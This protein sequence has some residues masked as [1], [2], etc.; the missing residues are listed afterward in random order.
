MLRNLLFIAIFVPGLFAA[1]RSRYAALLLYFWYAF[2]RPEDY[3]WLDVSALRLSLMLG[4]ILLVPALLSGEFPD[5]RHPLSVGAIVFFIAALVAQL[6]ALDPDTGWRW[7][8]FMTK[9]LLVSLLSTTLVRDRPKFLLAVAVIALSFGFHAS[10]AGLYSLLRGGAR[11]ADGFGGAYSDNNGYATAMAM[12]GPLLFCV[13]QN[14]TV[15]WLRWGCLMALPLVAL[16]VVATYSRSGFLALIGATL[17]MIV[18]QP[19]RRFSLLMLVACLSLPIAVF[20]SNQEGY[21]ERMQTIRTYREVNE[22]SAVSRTHFWRVAL[23]MVEANPLGVGLFNYEAAYDHYDFLHGQYG[24]KRSVHSSHFQVLAETGVLGALA[25][26]FN[27]SYAMLVLRRVRRRAATI[28]D[29]DNRRALTTGAN[30]LFASMV[31][32]LI[33]GAFIALALNDLTWITFGLVAALDRL[34]IKLQ[35]V[36]ALDDSPSRWRPNGRY[37]LDVRAPRVAGA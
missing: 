23:D 5:V 35:P 33:G 2:F 14:T 13:A 7:I 16:G 26:I 18:M 25:W 12:I 8:D 31:A 9:L 34:S 6:N 22:T 37:G 28:V 32:F 11:F 10:K 19:R 4:L 36:T 3:I 15:R 1:L 27:F 21:L 17:A 24:R 29:E 30:A 20:I